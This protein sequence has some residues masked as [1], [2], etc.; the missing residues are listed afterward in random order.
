MFLALSA[1]VLWAQANWLLLFVGFFACV[2]V[3][4][5]LLAIQLK[6]RKPGEK[7]VNLWPLIFLVGIACIVFILLYGLAVDATH[8]M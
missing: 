7:E 2:V 5:I 6:E 4:V 3:E 8:F 1:L